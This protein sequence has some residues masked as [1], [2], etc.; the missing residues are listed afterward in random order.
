MSLV[1]YDLERDLSIE[2]DVDRGILLGEASAYEVLSSGELILLLFPLQL[3]SISRGPAGNQDHV[4]TWAV[5]TFSYKVT[6]RVIN[7]F[8][9]AH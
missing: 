6:R 2:F 1:K 7:K 3:Y 9:D 5:A 8:I 4:I